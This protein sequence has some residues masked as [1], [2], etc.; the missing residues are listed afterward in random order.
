VALKK[1][2]KLILVK[3]AIVVTLTVLAVAAMISFRDYVNH[4][5]AKRAMGQLAQIVRQYRNNHG[6]VPPESY[7]ERIREQLHGHVRMGN[8]RYRARW[9]DLDS[10][11]DEILAY[12]RHNYRSPIVRDGVIVLRLDGRVEYMNKKQ[13]DEILAAQQGPEEIQFQQR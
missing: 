11:D 4:T 13:F 9:I 5:E 1:R 8:L 6:R 12:S 7:V 2:Q 10:T 3:F